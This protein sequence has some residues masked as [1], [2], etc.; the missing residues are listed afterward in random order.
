MDDAIVI[1]LGGSLLSSNNEGTLESWKSNFTDLIASVIS[2]KIRMVIV[3]GGG[4]LARENIKLAK[5]SGVSDPFELDLVGIEATRKN[6]KEIIGF[7]S[8]SNLMVDGVIPESISDCA[9]FLEKNNLVV[10]GGTVPGHTTD[11]VAIKMGA[12]LNS[13]CVIIATNVTHVFTSDPRLDSNAK[14]I[15]SMSLNELGII[16][17]IG[18]E[19]LPGSS[20]AVD[21]VGVNIAIEHNLPLVILNGHDVDNLRKAVNGEPFDGTNVYGVE[22]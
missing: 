17:G 16:S 15:E 18:K 5:K 21:P 11:T 12:K 14:P 13:K 1:A 10:M 20:F 4:K 22:N 9:S 8:N 2:K 19:I 7:F 3:V 6:A